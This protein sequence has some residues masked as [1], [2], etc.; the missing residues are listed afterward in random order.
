MIVEP[1]CHVITAESCHVR[2]VR[3]LEELWMVLKLLMFHAGNI[4]ADCI[5]FYCV[6]RKIVIPVYTFMLHANAFEETQTI[7]VRLSS[8]HSLWKASLSSV[9]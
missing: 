4:V 8:T 3:L 5:K 7:V 9:V 2:L 1:S 6:Y